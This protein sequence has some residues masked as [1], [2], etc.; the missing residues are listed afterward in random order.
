MLV[1]E[2]QVVVSQINKSRHLIY[3]I[4]AIVNIVFIKKRIDLKQ[5]NSKKF[6]ERMAD[7]YIH[8]LGYDVQPLKG[9]V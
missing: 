4:I 9:Y 5:M 3:V 7:E 2:Y 1:K 8:F 6:C